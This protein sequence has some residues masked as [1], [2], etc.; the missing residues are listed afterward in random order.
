MVFRDRSGV[1]Q[2][3][4]QDGGINA[5]DLAEGIAQLV[6]EQQVQQAEDLQAM[7]SGD[8]DW[9][10]LG[11]EA[12]DAAGFIPGWGTAADIVNA[13]WYLAEGDLENAIDSAISSIPILG[14]AYALLLLGEGI[15]EGM[16]EEGITVWDVIDTVREMTDSR[17][18][19]VLLSS[20]GKAAKGVGKAIGM[21]LKKAGKGG[22]SKAKPPIPRGKRLSKD[23]INEC[24]SKPGKAPIGEDGKPVELH[25]RHQG[26]NDPLDEMTREDHRGKG[27]YKKNHPNT[28]EKPSKIDRKEFRKQQKK[29]WRR[30]WDRGRWRKW[31]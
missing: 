16:E 29:Y 28:G 15:H 17:Q 4:S 9:S 7:L 23:K 12:L 20:T 6:I 11:H 26:P 13:M 21:A 31:G 25:H 14:D 24:P 2:Y 8:V 10:E 27:N 18:E 22:K 1:G 30:E 5:R 19:P 3:G